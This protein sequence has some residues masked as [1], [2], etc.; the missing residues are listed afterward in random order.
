MN[1]QHGPPCCAEGIR[2]FGD[3]TSRLMFV[4]ISPREAEMSAGKPDRGPAGRLMNDILDSVEWPRAQAYHT[5]TICYPCKE[6]TPQEIAICKPRLLQEIEWIKPR[7]IVCMGK[8]PAEAL[9]IT[10][11]GWIYPKQLHL[12]PHDPDAITYIMYTYHPSSVFQGNQFIYDIVRD[13]QKIPL[14]MNDER[15]PQRL[16][17]YTTID[18]PTTA[19]EILDSIRPG[20]RVA[21]DIETRL[22][23]PNTDDIDV[24]ADDLRCLS[25][26][27]GISSYVFTNTACQGLHWPVDKDIQWTFHNGPFDIMGMQQYLGTHLPIVEDTQYMS[28]ARDEFRGTATF[29]RQ[30]MNKLEDLAAEYFA[31]MDYKT[32]TKAYWRKKIEPPAQDLHKR[33]AYDAFYTYHLVDILRKFEPCPAYQTLLIKGGETFAEIVHHGVHIDTEAHRALAAEWGAAYIKLYAKLSEFTNKKPTSPRQVSRYMYGEDGLALPGGPSTAKAVLAALDH[34]F[35][36]DVTTFRNIEYLLKNWV[37]L[38]PKYIKR[39]GRLRYNVLLHG[40]ETGRRAYHDPPMQTI[41]KHGERLERIRALFSATNEDYVIIEA[42]YSQ[43]EMW[44]ARYLSEDEAMH[45]DLTRVIPILGKPD[46][47]YA[48]ALRLGAF[49]LLSSTDEARQVGKTANFLFQYG[50]GAGKL[51]ATL[52]ARGIDVS[53]QFCQEMVNRYRQSYPRFNEWC[54]KI[55]HEANTKGYISTP[56]GRYRRFPIITDPSWRS[57]IINFPVQSTAGDYTLS[58]IIDLHPLFKE[59]H[60]DAHILFDVHDSIVLEVHKDHVDEVVA[61]LH[62]VMEAPKVGL[63]SVKIDVK[64]GAHL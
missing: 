30:T 56:F 39:D 38:L 40:T 35:A 36:R 58:S 21:L 4:G 55:Y 45:E 18:D 9:G 11:R 64:I 62:E 19:Q 22:S 20:S 8:V 47:H 6:P 60:L 3:V 59:R 7:L 10:H 17:E 57:Q 33:N 42:D 23:D 52:H 32:V 44:I 1:E 2:G 53:M 37:L 12:D 41:P 34:P 49:D 24:Y 15:W 50:G 25:I 61:L 63:G 27:D 46:M 48:T 31:D 13:F 43:I 54:D 51:Q 14:V 16:E 5:N 28:Y 29:H 26:Y